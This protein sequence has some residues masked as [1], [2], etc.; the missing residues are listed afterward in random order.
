MHLNRENSGEFI[1]AQ[2]QSIWRPISSKEELGPQQPI[3]GIHEKFLLLDATPTGR[4][5]ISPQF[6]KW[7]PSIISESTI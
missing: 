4:K 1:I 5:D 3:T 2:E 6:G 7:G